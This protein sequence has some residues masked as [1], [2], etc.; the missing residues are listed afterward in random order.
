MAEL[1]TI[2]WRDIPAQVTARSGRRK[3]SIQLE[4]RF[5]VAIDKAA[6]RAGKETT[7]EYLA[8]WHRAVTECSE[9]L[10]A[11]ADRAAADLE[12]RFTDELLQTLITTGGIID[13]DVLP[14]IDKRKDRPS[15]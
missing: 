8:E 6:A 15:E 14:R 9:D 7:D 2:L 3:A 12:A 1:I 5:Q 13:G 4:D 10:Q 11:E